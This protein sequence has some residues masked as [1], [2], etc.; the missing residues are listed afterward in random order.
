MVYHGIHFCAN[1]LCSASAWMCSL[2]RFMYSWKDLKYPWCFFVFKYSTVFESTNT[3]GIGSRFLAYCHFWVGN[4]QKIYYFVSSHFHPKIFM[5]RFGNA[6]WRFRPSLKF[7]HSLLIMLWNHEVFTWSLG[8]FAFCTKKS[9][10]FFWMI[11]QII[12]IFRIL[13]I[14]LIIS[15]NLMLKCQVTLIR[16]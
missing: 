10:I 14:Q 16:S 9:W 4:T 2:P 12:G 7:A 11:S 1:F 8:F 3:M 13:V 6:V 15:E 5:Y